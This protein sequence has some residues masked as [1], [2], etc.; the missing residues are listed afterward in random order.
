MTAV[1]IAAKCGHIEVLKALLLQGVEVDDR[2]IVSLLIFFLMILVILL[3][4]VAKFQKL[5]YLN[6]C[7]YYFIFANVQKQKKAHKIV[8]IFF[9]S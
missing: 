7:Y 6:Q 1:H 9:C 8:F 2:D 5:Y 4:T 3:N